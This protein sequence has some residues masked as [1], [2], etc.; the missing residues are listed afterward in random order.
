MS[1]DQE[2][3]FQVGSALLDR[4]EAG[5]IFIPL[6]DITWL[7]L[8]GNDRGQVL[9][10][11][12]TNQVRSLQ[13]GQG[14]ETFITDVRGKTFGHAVVYA[15]DQ[16]LRLV[17]VPQQYERLAAHID[18]YVIREDVQV[19]D[20]SAETYSVFWPGI[21]QTPLATHWQL[22]A[23][24]AP[25]LGY[26]EIS[27][28]EFPITAYQVPITRSSDWIFATPVQHRDQLDALLVARDILPGNPQLMHCG[29]IGNRFPWFGVDF[30]ESNLPQELGRDKETICFTKGCYLGQETV[31]RL[32]AMG[33]VQKKML[34]WKFS[35]NQVPQKGTEITS[36]DKVVATVTSGTYCFAHGAPLALAMTRRSHFAKGATANSPIGPAEVV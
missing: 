21:E 17:S 10:N 4:F 24:D 33:Q 30:D 5:E 35:G 11:L 23:S 27:S 34:L 25:A 2:L 1:A 20:L 7:R 13:S 18:R 16:S 22:R 3:D 26:Q 14:V 8:T 28:E 6:P 36:G 12:T 9:G 19:Q 32:D 29:R 31:A 15:D